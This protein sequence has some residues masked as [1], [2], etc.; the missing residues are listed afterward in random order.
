[1]WTAWTRL[2]TCGCCSQYGWIRLLASYGESYFWYNYHGL[3][4]SIAE[5]IRPAAQ[6]LS[7]RVCSQ[8]RVAAAR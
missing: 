2:S 8:S 4:T 7:C 1:M 6:P 5:G 3:R